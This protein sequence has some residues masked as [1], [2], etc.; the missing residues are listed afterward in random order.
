LLVN[1]F[2]KARLTALIIPG[3]LMAGALG[4]QYIGG[5]LPC[6][7]CIWQRWPH[8]TAIGLAGLGFIVPQQRG[9][10]W[11]AALAI[12]ISG[13]TGI[14]HAGVEYKWWEGLTRCSQLPGSGGSGDIIAD[15]MKTPLVRCDEAQWRLFGISLAG[16]NA[17]ISISGAVLISRLLMRKN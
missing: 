10:I 1:A 11:L 6:E 8:Y 12:L 16:Y 5:L 3:A 9:L 15:I 13:V 4:S 7:M 2:A 17:I 14:F